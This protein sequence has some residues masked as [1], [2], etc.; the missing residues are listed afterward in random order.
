MLIVDTSFKSICCHSGRKSECCTLQEKIKLFSER[1]RKRG[2]GFRSFFL[3]NNMCYSPCVLPTPTTPAKG[4][5]TSRGPV[6]NWNLVFALAKSV[7]TTTFSEHT[8]YNPLVKIRDMLIP[9][10]KI[11]SFMQIKNRHLCLQPMLVSLCTLHSLF[12]HLPTV[13]TS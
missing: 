10:L 9:A 4:A 6:Q 12:Y 5:F 13:T 2:A 1:G 3:L 11:S 8:N 7:A